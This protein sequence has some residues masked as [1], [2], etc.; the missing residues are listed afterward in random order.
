MADLKPFVCMAENCEMKLFPDSHTWMTH[1]LQ[2]HLVEWKC[3]FCTRTPFG[4]L[5]SFESHIRT[6]HARQ[7]DGERL[8]NLV[9]AC[10]LPLD[11]LQPSD[12]KICDKWE[13]SLR[14]INSHISADETMVVTPQQFRHHVRGHM[15]QLALFAIARGDREDAGSSNAAAGH[16][17]DDDLYDASQPAMASYEDQGNP[18]SHIAAFEGREDEIN[19]LI[20][21]HRGKSSSQVLFEK[22]PTW[23]S[24]E[25]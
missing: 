6:T 5:S 9:R 23:G 13:A 12:C 14:E 21:A 10:Q 20:S 18:R 1:E 2:N 8:K 19:E 7:V 15:E 25:S 17:S 3:C 4:T 22:G 24:S 11:K 16:E